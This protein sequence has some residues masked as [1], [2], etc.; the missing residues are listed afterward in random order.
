MNSVVLQKQQPL[1]IITKSIKQHPNFKAQTLDEIQPLE[2]YGIGSTIVFDGMLLS[3]QA[4]SIG[5]SF[6]GGRHQHIDF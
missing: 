1:F 4:S 3:K 5:L 6:C 2:N